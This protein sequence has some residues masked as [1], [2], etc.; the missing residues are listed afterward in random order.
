MYI[1]YHVFG[2]V[3]D[4]FGSGSLCHGLV[5][6]WIVTKWGS[7]PEIGHISQFCVATL[8]RKLVRILMFRNTYIV[9]S[10][11]NCSV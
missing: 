11:H 2:G 10:V 3:L 5:M 6:C 1:M 7:C 4:V 9:Y 8:L